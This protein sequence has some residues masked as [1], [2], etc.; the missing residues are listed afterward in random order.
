MSFLNYVWNRFVSLFREVGGTQPN[1]SFELVEAVSVDEATKS[2]EFD[3]GSGDVCRLEYA[4][5]APGFP[6]GFG[7]EVFAC[8]DGTPLPKRYHPRAARLAS[9]LSLLEESLGKPVEV[10]EGFRTAEYNKQVRGSKTTPQLEGLG[11]RI[12]VKGVGRE[13]LAKK[14]KEL[15]K[16][17]TLEKGAVAVYPDSV[18]YDV[19]GKNLSWTVTSRKK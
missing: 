16:E 3:V 12:K 7:P 4:T 14:I 1:N 15:I 9:N 2:V 6:E 10:V 18:Y 19:R 13:R 17:G 5:T 8:K 11:A